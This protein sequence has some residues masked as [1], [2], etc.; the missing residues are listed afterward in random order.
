MAVSTVTRAPHQVYRLADG[1]KVPGVTSIL[2]TI[3]KPALSAWANRL[4]FNRV[5]S[6]VRLDFLAGAGSLAHSLIAQRLG[7]SVADFYGYTPV[8]VSMAE[9]A[10]GGFL[11]WAE[12][13]SLEAHET[14]L[15]LISETHGYGGTLDALVVV[16]G[17]LTVIDFK[18]SGRIYPDHLYQLSAYHHLLIENDYTVDGAM[19]LRLS[20]DVSGEYSE[21]MLSV[22]ELAP[23][24]NVFKA[25]LDLHDAIKLATRRGARRW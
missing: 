15:S 3:A 9:R 7:G 23:Y 11:A 1:T 5:N 22:S 4:G 16:D 17:V 19:V 13:K 10:L 12:G 21:R 20:R 25:A 6:A 2:A 24:F 8:Q 14:E 18:T